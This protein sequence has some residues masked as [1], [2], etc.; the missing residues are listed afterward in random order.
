MKNKTFKIKDPNYRNIIK[1][2]FKMIYIGPNIKTK[3]KDLL[4]AEKDKRHLIIFSILNSD[5]TR[6]F[7]W[8]HRW[9]KTFSQY[10]ALF[11]Q[12]NKLIGKVERNQEKLVYWILH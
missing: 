12:K 8:I 5:S 3:R 4:Y 11:C 1:K 10:F 2:E 7:R 9:K 6:N